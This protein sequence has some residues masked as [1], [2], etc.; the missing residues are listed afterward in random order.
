MVV[1]LITGALMMSNK[2]YNLEIA[3]FN[4]TTTAK[5]NSPIQT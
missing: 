1:V 4:G 3:A 5:Y 2:W